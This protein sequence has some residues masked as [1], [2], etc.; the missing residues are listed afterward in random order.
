MMAF[1]FED[2]FE[3]IDEALQEV[4]ATIFRI[5]QDPL[6]LMQPEW[7]TQL[8]RM[9]ECYNVTIEEEDEDPQKINIPETEGHHEVQGPQIEKPNITALVR[10]KQVNIG[11]KAEPKFTNIGDYWDDAMV[12]KVDE[13]LPEYQDS[14]P[15]K[16]TDLKGIIAYLGVMKIT[17]KH[18][19]KPVRQ[20]PYLLN[21]KYK[22][23]VRL[24]L[25]KMLAVGIVEPMEESDWVSPMV[26]QEKNQKDEIRICVDLRKLNDACVEFFYKTSLWYHVEFFYISASSDTM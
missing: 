18:N 10:T 22:E 7:A 2:G 6:D 25:D 14:F 1:S 11:T 26:V 12:D 19:A 8:S 24:E 3:G 15:T 16:F 23:K 13:L 20:R 9:L 4:K 5:Q 17:L 21:P